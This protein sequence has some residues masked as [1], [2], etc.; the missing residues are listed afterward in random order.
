MS[1]N[2]LYCPRFLFVEA[3]NYSLSSL[4]LFSIRL[5]DSIRLSC[6]QFIQRLSRASQGSDDAELWSARR[7]ILSFYA[8]FISSLTLDFFLSSSFYN[9]NPYFDS[10]YMSFL[11]KC[12]LTP[13]TS[14]TPTPSSP[15]LRRSYFGE[16]MGVQLV[17]LVASKVA[18]PTKA[19]SVNLLDL[20]PP[21]MAAIYAAPSSLLLRPLPSSSEEIPVHLRRCPSVAGERAEYIS[22]IKRLLSL[23]MVSFTF[24]PKCVN[25]L[26]GV[27]KDVT[28]IRLIIDAR[29]GNMMFSDPPPVQLPNPSHITRL[30]SS[31]SKPLYVAKCDLDN[32][33]HQLILPEW[34]SEYLALP[35]LS[36]EEYN[37]TC[38]SPSVFVPTS[39]KIYPMCRTLPMGWSHS[40]FLGQVVHEWVLY[41]NFPSSVP[42]PP[43]LSEQDNILFLASPKV[44]RTLHGVV[45]DDIAFFSDSLSDCTSQF[46]NA[47]ARY[48]MAGLAVK[49]KKS[50]PPSATPSPIEVL[51]ITIDPA[52]KCLYLSPAKTVTLIEH[53]F[54]VLSQP[55]VSGRQLSALIGRWLWVMLLNRPTLSILQASYR[56][57]EFVGERPFTLWNSVKREIVILLTI[58]PLLRF[59]LD[60][61]WFPSL[62]AT[63]ASNWG[64]GVTATPLTDY[65]LESLWPASASKHS[66]FFVM[67]SMLKVVKS[68]VDSLPTLPDDSASSSLLIQPALAANVRNNPAYVPLYGTVTQQ[69]VYPLLQSSR[70]QI[71]SA[72]LRS[73]ASN[74]YAHWT[75]WISTPWRYAQHINALEM[76]SVVLALRRILSSPQSVGRRILLMSDSSSVAFTL[77]KG[78]SSAPALISGMR[79]CAALLLASSCQLQILWIPTSFNPADD[80]SRWKEDVD[81]PPL[82][83]IPP[84]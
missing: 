26:F 42:R 4:P 37:S 47:I 14:N 32:F 36:L 55:T 33:Y 67:S 40:V 27:E 60:S 5:M 19:S 64:G 46:N 39:D 17:S 15:P 79:K 12:G 28:M 68:P 23:S 45:I 50:V 57:I 77:M 21:H 20:L 34:I 76:S 61:L 58:L 72:L 25:G 29:W 48:Q 13:L 24:S 53:S 56:Y 84:S 62:I 9:F 43:S 16:P 74:D 52:R 10:S 18:L 69:G 71:D 2:Y 38:G 51:G 70:I 63:D 80:P 22:L 49:A 66:L 8:V 1:L 75:T 6:K 65:L 11:S 59:S 73:V 82:L 44:N 78:R 83:G 41:G 35:S 54:R 31:P 3:S 81:H 30:F 7:K